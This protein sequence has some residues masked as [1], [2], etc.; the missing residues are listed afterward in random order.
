MA[1]DAAEL[2]YIQSTVGAFVARRQPPERIRHQLRYEMEVD[3]H[4]VT[5]WEFRPA[6]MGPGESKAA[7]ARFR[8]TRTRGEWA[9][10]WMRRDLKWHRYEE[11][12]PSPYLEPL[13]AEVDEDPFGCFFG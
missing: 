11:A 5:I 3:G 1:F 6:F 13:V 7:V 4:A 12:A 9:L 8:F 10:Y 2:G